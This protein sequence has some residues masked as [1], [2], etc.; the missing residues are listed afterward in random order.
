M[1]CTATTRTC[2]TVRPRPAP[3]LPGRAGSRG[4]RPHPP[5]APRRG[6]L[7]RPQPGLR[8]RRS[9]G[10]LQ[11]HG[12]RRDLPLPRQKVRDRE[13]LGA[14]GGG[15]GGSGC[16]PPPQHPGRA[17]PTPRPQHT[18]PALSFLRAT[19]IEHLVCA[20]CWGLSRELKHHHLSFMGL[21]SYEEDRHRKLVKKSGMLANL[22]RSDN[23]DALTYRALT[24]SCARSVII[25]QTRTPRP[26][27]VTRLPMT[28]WL[29]SQ[30]LTTRLPAS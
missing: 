9:Q 13:C 17:V 3:P 27:E 24:T 8:A 11:L 22:Q 26:R 23:L 12:G 25:P 7:D 6:I 5:L 29:Q 1:S 16:I 21:A 14:S 15:G 30:P 2:P 18:H 20:K 19:F 10:F 28:V 4:A